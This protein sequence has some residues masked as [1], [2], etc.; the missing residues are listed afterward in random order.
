MKDKVVIITGGSL[1]IGKACALEFGRKGSKVVIAAR[2]EHTL[3]KT[4]EELK[5]EGIDC[6]SI[7][8]DV[9]D[10]NDCKKIIQK[11]INTYGRIDV[12]LNNAGISMRAAFADLDLSVIRSLMDV[13]FWGTVYCTKY[14][15]PELLKSKGSV[16]GVASIAGYVGLPGRTGYSASKYAMKGF[17]DALRNENRNTGLHVMVACPGYTASNIRKA[18]LVADGSKQGETPLDEDKLMT[19]EEVAKHIYDA[20]KN[21][22]REIILTS[23]GKLAVW[24]N[25]LFPKL[26][27][28]LVYKTVV[29]EPG[30][31]FK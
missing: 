8:A 30:S 10:E 3:A 14:A 17:M 2:N 28:K 31:P 9:S 24:I 15:M 6:I 4:E 12:L 18:A 26:S 11:T 29:K 20:V 21:R 16:V 13:N 5:Q 19:A 27:D 1:G 7:Q 25:K 23:Q 22:K